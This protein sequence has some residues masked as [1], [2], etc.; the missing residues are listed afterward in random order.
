MGRGKVTRRDANWWSPLNQAYRHFIEAHGHKPDRA[1]LERCEMGVVHARELVSTA[2]GQVRPR[3]PPAEDAP[4]AVMSRLPDRRALSRAEPLPGCM[5]KPRQA[6]L[7]LGPPA[8]GKGR[9]GSALLARVLLQRHRRWRGAASASAHADPV[10][11]ARRAPRPAPGRVRE[12]GWRSSGRWAV[13]RIDPVG[14]RCAG[15]RLCKHRRCC[16]PCCKGLLCSCSAACASEPPRARH[17][18]SQPNSPNVSV[19]CRCRAFAAGLRSTGMRRGP[20]GT[21]LL[22]SMPGTTANV[23]ALWTR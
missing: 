1:W 3:E 19:H 2:G 13:V 23:C 21:G 18:T 7:L 16:N 20:M 4:C 8:T 15:C 9:S 10:D 14:G 6:A 11:T 17:D 22:S 12:R 5:L